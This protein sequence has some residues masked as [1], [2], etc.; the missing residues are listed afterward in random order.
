MTSYHLCFSTVLTFVSLDACWSM[1]HHSKGAL[2]QCC[3]A[4]LPICGAWILNHRGMVRLNSSSCSFFCAHH[5]LKNKNL[6]LA[7]HV[8]IS[9]P[10][11]LQIIACFC[12]FWWGTQVSFKYILHFSWTWEVHLVCYRR[13][14]IE[15][16]CQDK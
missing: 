15:N 8:S 1:G 9:I 4:W 12:S 10:A 3:G 11:S 2:K 6:T 5:P 13:L 7:V 14:T 16:K